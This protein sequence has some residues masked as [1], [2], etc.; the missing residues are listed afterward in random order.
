MKGVS[1]IWHTFSF[2]YNRKIVNLLSESIFIDIF[3]V[4]IEKI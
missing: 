1:K 3:V 4:I 2:L